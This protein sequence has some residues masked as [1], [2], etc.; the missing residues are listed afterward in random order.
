VTVQDWPT[1][2]EL[3]QVVVE[4]NGGPLLTRRTVMEG[5]PRGFRLA[6][7]KVWES[8]WPE[9]TWPKL[10]TLLTMSAP[11]TVSVPEPVP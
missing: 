11:V 7:L 2:R 6:R 9:V 10:K 4:R 5:E 1:G 3:P 8:V